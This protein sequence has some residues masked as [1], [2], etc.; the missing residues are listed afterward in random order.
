MKV[1]DVVMKYARDDREMPFYD[2]ELS[3][4][5]SLSAN[6]EMMLRFAMTYRA[7]C[8]PKDC[9][10]IIN[11]LKR[12]VLDYDKKFLNL[13]YLTRKFNGTKIVAGM[14]IV[15]V[16]NVYSIESSIDADFYPS[17]NVAYIYKRTHILKD[18]FSTDSV[19]EEYPFSRE[20]YYKLAGK[21][22]DDLKYRTMLRKVMEEGWMPELTR[23]YEIINGYE[24]F[25]EGMS[26]EDQLVCRL[27]D[28]K[29]N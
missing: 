20:N 10:W 8:L 13:P 14:A 24:K 12:G 16:D 3:M 19:I 26:E 9:L 21:D 1:V 25:L 15:P 23:A 22:A 11:E 2:S 6:Y 18:G 28:Q 7:L 4:L 5:E 29:A 17:M 27:L